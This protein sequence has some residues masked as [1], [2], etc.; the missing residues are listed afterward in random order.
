MVVPLVWRRPQLG[1]LGTVPLL[2]RTQCYDIRPVRPVV[3]LLWRPRLLGVL[4]SMLLL[5][6]PQF[7]VVW[8]LG[9][10]WWCE[11][12]LRVRPLVP[13]AGV[14]LVVAVA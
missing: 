13:L 9:L 11:R 2:W 10:L 5:W 7:L 8:F 12:R 14:G 6:Q 1:V 4:R 3:S